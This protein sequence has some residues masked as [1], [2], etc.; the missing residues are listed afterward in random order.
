MTAKLLK[1]HSLLSL[2]AV[3]VGAACLL[4]AMLI[5]SY[6]LFIVALVIMGGGG[7]WWLITAV[8]IWWHHG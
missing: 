5:G 4:P 6:D 7:I 1:L 3:S 2:G 8:R